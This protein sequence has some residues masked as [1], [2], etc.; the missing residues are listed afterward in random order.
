MRKPWTNMG[1][2]SEPRVSRPPRC[3]FPLRAKICE[4]ARRLLVCGTKFTRLYL[5]P[6]GRAGWSSRFQRMIF[7]KRVRASVL[8]HTAL[9][10]TSTLSAIP[11]AIL[12]CSSVCLQAGSGAYGHSVMG[13]DKRRVNGALRSNQVLFPTVRFSGSLTE[14]YKMG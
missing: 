10:W 3:P 2:R 9:S 6:L 1:G 5:K 14:A 11:V 8:E 4:G 13:Y 7:G 12:S